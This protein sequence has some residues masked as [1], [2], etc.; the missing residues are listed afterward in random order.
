MQFIAKR[1]RSVKHITPEAQAFLTFEQSL[2][3]RLSRRHTNLP[4]PTRLII[5]AATLLGSHPPRPLAFGANNADT[6]PTLIDPH[7]PHGPTCLGASSSLSLYKT[8][9][10]LNYIHGFSENSKVTPG[11]R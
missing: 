10:S 7:V 1:I 6:A 3:A 4:A 5:K 2:A 8:V 11:L 9:R